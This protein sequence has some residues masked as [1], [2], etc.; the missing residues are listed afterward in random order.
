MELLRFQDVRMDYGHKPIL[1]G[2]SFSINAG[3][4]VGLIGANGAGKTTIL[5]LLLGTERP[6]A[7]VI[8][9]A[10]GLGVG[11]VPQYAEI[12]EG[13]T[14]LEAVLAD[15]S[16]AEVA[17]RSAEEQLA[18]ASA[19]ELHGAIASHDVA[20]EEYEAAGGDGAYAGAESLLDALGLAGRGGDAAA[21]LSGGEKNVLS[22]ARA[23]LIEPDLL[24]LDEPG[25]HLD[26]AGLAW[27]EGYLSSFRGAVLIVSHNRYLLDRIAGRILHLHNG[28]VDSYVGNYSAYRAESLKQKLAQRADY[29]ANQKRLAQLEDLVR[30]F[31]E[32]ASR[33]SDP[34][35]GKRLRARV[36]QLDRERSQAVE[37]PDAEAS[38]LRLT[39]TRDTSKAAV[40]LQVR[41]YSK[42]FGGRRLFEDASLDV[43]V[44]QRVALIGPN[45]CGKTTFLR[46]V[47]AEGAWD[48]AT[49]R[50]GPS[51]RVGYCA[52][53]QDILDDHRTVMQQVLAE[54]G[55]T[56]ERAFSVLTRFMFGA[57]DLETRVGDLSGGERNR[58]QLA[59]LTIRQPDFLIL[60]EPTN[61]LDI[62]ACEAIEDALADFNGTV[63]VVSH[64]R[65]LLD[66]VA[67]Y[68][69]EVKECGFEIQAGNFSEY[70]ASKPDATRELARVATRSSVR[71]NK[72]NKA[73]S[74]DA[75]AAS[76]VAQRI[77]EAER[78]R[79]RLEARV[80]QAF[81]RGDQREGARATKLLEQQRRRIDEL[82]RSWLDLDESKR[83]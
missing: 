38:P 14:V 46:D 71:R 54:D 25:N 50:I 9:R 47:I 66:K 8:T 1:A 3:E 70:W 7:G 11:Y 79:D 43:G 81:T 82:Y 61:H 17:L 18:N 67:D 12:E 77:E 45:G 24:A 26:F 34:G 56:R 29:V 28:A 51:L 52:Q 5:K 63:L 6:A 69:V 64:D 60:D 10:K 4:K 44:G 78:E 13:A 74:P 20:R 31:R 32:I 80:S 68:V 27:L 37:K 19:S 73:H 21:R 41:G 62:P 39:L 72:P 75:A 16:A 36:S 48:G 42:A 30:R 55:M 40:A 49:I 15:H 58:L 35:W 22:L 53:E 83:S 57:R 2:T 23:L 76:D 33:T 59:L 65:Y